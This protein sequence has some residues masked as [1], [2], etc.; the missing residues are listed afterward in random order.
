MPFPR[1]S[2]FYFMYTS[3]LCHAECY[4]FIKNVCPGKLTWGVIGYLNG[5]T[6]C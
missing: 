1:C 5:S 4:Q 6:K 3:K 2:A